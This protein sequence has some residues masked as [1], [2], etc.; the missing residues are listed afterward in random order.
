VT[1]ADGTLAGENR[2]E[3][4]AGGCVLHE[5]WRGAEGTT[6]SSLNAYDRSDRRWHQVW[7][8]SNGLRLDLSGG[9]TDGRMVMS[10]ERPSRDGGRVHHRISW[11]P[12]PDGGLRQMWEVS[13]DAGATWSVVFDGRYTRKQ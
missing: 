6:G 13:R 9:V 3:P 5:R 7:M 1:A 2:I 4:T 11:E 10:G 12:R 8:D